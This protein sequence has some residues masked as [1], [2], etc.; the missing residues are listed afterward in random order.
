MSEYTA[1]KYICQIDALRIECQN[2]YIYSQNILCQLDTVRIC[3]RFFHVS[4]WG[5]RK[6]NVIEVICFTLVAGVVSPMASSLFS[7]P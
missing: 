2:I 6:K 5:S 4:R 1:R 7:G 3:V